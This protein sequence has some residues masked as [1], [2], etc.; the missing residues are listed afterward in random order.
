MDR[1][2]S[3]PTLLTVTLCTLAGATGLLACAGPPPLKGQEAQE[4]QEQREVEMTRV[5]FRNVS[6]GVEPDSFAAGPRTLYRAGLY[7]GRL[8]HPPDPE[9]GEHMV[10]IVNEPH[11][12]LLDRARGEARYIRDPGPTYAFRAPILDR[13]EVP[14]AM[15]V[16]EFGREIA[17][18]QALGARPRETTNEDGR[19]VVRWEAEYEDYRMLLLA[20]AESGLPRDL[21]IQKDGALAKA[22]RYEDYQV[23]LDLDPSLFVP[24]PGVKVLVHGPPPGASDAP[25][26]P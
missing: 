20:D 3:L 17:F 2:R 26:Q 5:V 23:G 19:P 15:A 16:L 1:H 9:T 4:P 8:E 21:R 12:F 13:S 24:P 6:P 14:P 18:M 22:Y 10:V 25:P 11:G 7:L